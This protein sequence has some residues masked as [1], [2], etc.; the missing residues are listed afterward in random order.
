LHQ[1]QQVILQQERL[2]ALGEMAS[3]I[4]HD[5]NNAISPVALY[6]EALLEREPNLSEHARAYLTTIQGAIDNVAQTI[7]RMRAFSRPREPETT[8]TSVDANTL[9]QQVIDLT[10]ARW[11]DIAQR[12]GIDIRLRHEP[13]QNLPAIPGVENEIRDA[14][15]NLIFNAV[16][17]MPSGGTLSLRTAL[18]RSTD[19]AG[20]PAV[21]LEVRDTGSGMDEATRRRCLEPFF[22]TKGEQGT[23]MGLAMVFGMAQRHGAELEIESAVGVGTAMRLIFPGASA[24]SD[25][26]ADRQIAQMPM[27]AL[28]ILVVD[29]D[30]LVVRSLRDILTT[31]GHIVTAADGGQAGIDAFL[32]SRS[33]A[34]FA[35]VITDL[36]MPFV[37][38]RKV[39]AAIKAASPATPVVLL[40]G[41]GHRLLEDKDVPPNVDR[42][43]AKPPRLQQLRSTLAS[44]IEVR[45]SEL[46]VQL[47]EPA[48]AGAHLA[49]PH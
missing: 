8:F 19:T 33:E 36:G 13:A 1:S 46:P 31:D 14:L 39:A 49:P 48:T 22:T 27:R 32:A 12:R 34:P 23:G 28:R 2:R 38:G 18:V 44:L 15:T 41:W 7:T 42:V 37:D 35:A 11:C 29:D 30:P 26:I 5:I 40:T 3:G 24:V 6:T 16:D 10:R 17:A 43:L 47:S 20:G 21:L 4:A 45:R 9:V 25:A